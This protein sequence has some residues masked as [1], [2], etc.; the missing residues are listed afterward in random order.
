M[1]ILQAIAQDTTHIQ[2]LVEEA[3][4][5]EKSRQHQKANDKYEEALDVLSQDD[6]PAAY[7]WTIHANMG[8]NL[9]KAGLNIDALVHLKEALHFYENRTEGYSTDPLYWRMDIGTLYFQLGKPDSTFV[10]YKSAYRRAKDYFG[11]NDFNRYL[12]CYKMGTYHNDVP[13]QEFEKAVYYYSE[14]LRLAKRHYPQG[15]IELARAYYSLA[16]ALNN[17]RN[18]QRS[19]TY[20]DSARQINPKVCRPE[21]KAEFYYRGAQWALDNGRLAEAKQYFLE[22]GN[23]LVTEQVVNDLE[24]S[25]WLQVAGILM[26]EGKFSEAKQYLERSCE[27]FRRDYGLN[28]Y[29]T[30]QVCAMAED[31]DYANYDNLKSLF[32]SKTDEDIHEIL[33]GLMKNAPTDSTLD[34]LYERLK[35]GQAKDSLSNDLLMAMLKVQKG[36]CEEALEISQSVLITLIPKFTESSYQAE[37]EAGSV[38]NR[39]V[40]FLNA[41]LV[42]SMA[43][44]CQWQQNG[45]LSSLKRSF[46]L[47]EKCDTLM[48]NIRLYSLDRD[49]ANFGYFFSMVYQNMVGLAATLQGQTKDFTYFE[50]AFYASEKLKAFSLL[51][52]TI[53]EKQLASLA[54]EDL[55]RRE[56]KLKRKVLRINQEIASKA[57]HST[58]EES[59]NKLLDTQAKLRILQLKLKNQYSKYWKA[60]YGGSVAKLKEFVNSLDDETIVLVYNYSMGDML[61][62]FMLSKKQSNFYVGERVNGLSDKIGKLNELITK[63]KVDLALYR[64]LINDLS[65]ILIPDLP[66]QIENIVVIPDGKLHDLPFQILAERNVGESAERFTDIPFLIKKYTISYSLSASIYHWQSQERETRTYP[67][68]MLGY[69]PLKFG[70]LQSIIEEEGDSVDILAGKKANREDLFSRSL[71]DYQVVQITSHAMVTQDK[72]V[73]GIVFGEG[74]IETIRYGDFY[75]LEAPV[76]LFVLMGCTTAKGALIPGEGVVGLN[77]A[78]FIAGSSRILLS[79]FAVNTAADQAFNRVFYKALIENKD[80]SYP[81]AL[82]KALLFLLNDPK[83]SAPHLWAGYY[84]I[85]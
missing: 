32:S 17:N 39:P 29:R 30:K 6:Y 54:P 53:D 20:L 47:L 49:K 27:A 14:A 77:K 10:Y 2:N 21:E 9:V 70:S 69:D 63:K 1:S 64:T 38:T 55:L 46:R 3:L 73:S 59:K 66:A 8:Y 40:T 71:E 65:S 25:A 35:E 48:N 37:P 76:D 36:D 61:D 75:S 41:L 19:V 82:R 11:K 28:D 52:E 58:A 22:A 16:G 5:L 4:E 57:P 15:H 83:F 31:I 42:K 34:V 81:E 74:G 72:A 78:L 44:Q 51:P 56:E 68:F 80:I 13:S 45:Q 67:K 50:K 7:R 43:Y 23:A 12:F 26:R 79:K 60:K 24:G 33:K 84:L 18:I 62:I 85:R